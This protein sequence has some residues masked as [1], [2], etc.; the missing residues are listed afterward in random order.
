MPESNSRPNV[1]EG[2]EVPTELPGSTGE[3][4]YLC[5]V[6]QWVSPRH[7]FF[8]PSPYFRMVR[9]HYHR[10][11][12]V[13]SLTMYYSVS[14]YILWLCVAINTSVQYNGGLLGFSRQY[15]ILQHS[16]PWRIGTTWFSS[17]QRATGFVVFKKNFD[18][19]PLFLV[20]SSY[21]LC[22]STAHCSILPFLSRA[23]APLKGVN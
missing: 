2:Y 1:S 14:C 17:G 21:I 4:Y 12:L 10:I 8:Y 16:R 9:W 23:C 7:L 18:Y 5:T 13:P 15:S 6:Q 19:I 20:Q 22:C 3:M 11:L